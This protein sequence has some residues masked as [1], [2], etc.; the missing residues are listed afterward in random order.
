MCKLTIGNLDF[1]YVWIQNKKKHILNCSHYS[2]YYTKY[3]IFLY[4]YNVHILQKALN[5]LW[6]ISLF[7]ISNSVLIWSFEF[8]R[9]F[10][11]YKLSYFYYCLLW[12]RYSG[13]IYNIYYLQLISCRYKCQPKVCIGNS[14]DCSVMAIFNT[15]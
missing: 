15:L 12:F 11:I 8:S 14:D 13:Q 10:L 5:F 2:K 4:R 7:F 6:E 1:L 3:I 9:V